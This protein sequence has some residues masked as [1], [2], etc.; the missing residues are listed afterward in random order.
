MTSKDLPLFV[1]N[2]FLKQINDIKINLI[3][4]IAKDF[5]L[6]E[7]ELLKIYI[8]DIEIVNKNL[9]NIKIVKKNKYN[10]N[11]KE[12]NRCEARV[13]NNGRGSRCR[14]RKNHDNLCTMHNNYKKNNHGKL[15]YGLITEEKPK[16]YFPTI[17][18]R[19]EK[20]Y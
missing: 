7:E 12:E 14:R 17:D 10:Q 9:E 5:W 3:K 20:I 6:D 8:C 11:I 4:Q 1:I 15:K 13:Y 19:K 2:L 18:N 16:K